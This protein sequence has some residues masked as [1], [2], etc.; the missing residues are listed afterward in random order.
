MEEN[1]KE[2][3]QLAILAYWATHSRTINDYSVQH[4]RENAKIISQKCSPLFSEANDG[5]PN[6]GWEGWTV[7]ALLCGGFCAFRG[8]PSQSEL[9]SLLD[10]A[11][12]I[13]NRV[14]S[15]KHEQ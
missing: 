13:F 11:I 9:E 14:E 8:L 1:F 12:S 7:F 4:A 2:I 10:K 6:D 15:Q 5:Y 3:V